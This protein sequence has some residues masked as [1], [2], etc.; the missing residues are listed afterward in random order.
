[1]HL[2]WSMHFLEQDSVH[3]PAFRVFKIWTKFMVGEYGVDSVNK[4]A[5]V[6]IVFFFM[7]LAVITSL[8]GTSV[9]EVFRTEKALDSNQVRD[10][11]L[12]QIIQDGVAVQSGTVQEDWLNARIQ[13]MHTI[14]FINN[15]RTY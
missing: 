7:R 10:S 5:V 15:E 11:Q 8:V 2:Y 9:T 3:N 12:K 1:M 4:G 13:K 6:V 14:K